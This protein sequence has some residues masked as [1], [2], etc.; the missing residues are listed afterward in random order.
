[1]PCAD[2]EVM[3]Q[4]SKVLGEP[5]ASAI[6]FPKT[7]SYSSFHAVGRIAKIT[8]GEGFFDFEVDRALEMMRGGGQEIGRYAAVLILY[9]LSSNAP[10]VFMRCVVSVL[11]MIWTPLKDHRVSLV[12]LPS[13]T[14]TDLVCYQT[15]VRERT[16]MLLGSC[17]E[18]IHS[19]ESQFKA[20][21][22]KKILDEAERTLNKPAPSQDVIHGG[23][24]A[25]QSLLNHSEM[26]R[27]LFSR[28]TAY[29]DH[30][31]RSR[32]L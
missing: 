15:V 30:T 14:M 1:M 5:R 19:R 22:Y 6:S 13:E 29:A 20:Q 23:L 24:L 9:Q 16:S 10:A 28:S 3:V 21:Q 18:L 17:F 26:V 8:Q 4:A 25:L 11:D 27:N 2:A 7:Y 32:S 31:V 12:T